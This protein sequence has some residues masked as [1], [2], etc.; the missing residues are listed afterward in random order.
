MR[1]RIV[2]AL[3]WLC[4]VTGHRFGCRLATLSLDLDDRWGTQ[5]WTGPNPVL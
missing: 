4:S 2:I 5:A 3:E 1:K